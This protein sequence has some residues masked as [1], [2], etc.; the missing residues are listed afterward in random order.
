MLRGVAFVG[1]LTEAECTQALALGVRKPSI[2]FEPFMYCV[3][4]MSSHL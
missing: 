3:A 2:S 1:R 4:F